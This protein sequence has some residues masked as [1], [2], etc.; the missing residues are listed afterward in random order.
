MNGL[1]KYQIEEISTKRREAIMSEQIQV[2]L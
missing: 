1:M 2:K